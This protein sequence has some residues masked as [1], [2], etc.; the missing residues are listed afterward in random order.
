MKTKTVQQQ[1]QFGVH[2]QRER[3]RQKMDQA[4]RELDNRIEEEDDRRRE[5]EDEIKQMEILE[6]EL[7]KKLQ[8]TQNI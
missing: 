8:N 1:Y 4:K 5:K 2:K 7:I 3:D 6:M